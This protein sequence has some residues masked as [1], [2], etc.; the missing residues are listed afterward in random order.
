MEALHLRS[1]AAGWAVFLLLATGCTAKGMPEGTGQQ[2]DDPSITARVMAALA[3][4][5]SIRTDRINVETSGG[6]VALSGIAG[7]RDAV[8]Q[9][10]DAAA[11]VPGVVSVRNDLIVP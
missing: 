11:S 2:L 3:D 4:I 8:R 7:S 5:P 6:E 1:L 10:T 9:A